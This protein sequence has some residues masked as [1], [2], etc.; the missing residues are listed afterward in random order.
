MDIIWRQA[1]PVDRACLAEMIFVPCS[2]EFS[3]SPDQAEIIVYKIDCFSTHA[4][5]LIKVPSRLTGMD[6]SY[7][8]ISPGLAE[9]PAKSSKISARWAGSLLI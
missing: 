9:I 8:K 2:Y 6:C 1:G 3:I 4:R 5:L 7:R